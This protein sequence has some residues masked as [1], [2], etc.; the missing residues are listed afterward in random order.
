MIP[1]EIR[2]AFEEMHA[3]CFAFKHSRH[4]GDA[5]RDAWSKMEDRLSRMHDALEIFLLGRA[6][7]FVVPVPH[8]D[9]VCVADWRRVEGHDHALVLAEEHWRFASPLT[10]SFFRG[11]EAHHPDA[12]ACVAIFERGQLNLKLL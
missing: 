5:H 3:L 6:P 4:V 10:P 1:A 11:C 2:T 7:L 9:A 12:R 8:G